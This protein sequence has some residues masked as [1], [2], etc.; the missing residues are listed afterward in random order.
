V[1]V[2]VEGTPQDII[3][4]CVRLAERAGSRSWELAWECPHLPEAEH[5]ERHRCEAITWVAT[6]E[7]AQGPITERAATPHEAALALAVRLMDGA[8]CRCGR[9]VTLS[10]NSSSKRC[11]WRLEG[12]AWMPG[13]TAPPLE[14]GARG[15][16][17]GMLAAL[18]GGNREQRRAAA[19]L[20]KRR[21]RGQ[22]GS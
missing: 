15:D 6:A 11:R 8:A 19:R 9:D 5:E 2:T 13:C 20:A 7:Y 10:A 1:T 3:T 17:V 14:A 16:Y 12:D 18:G 22:R 21:K 4:A